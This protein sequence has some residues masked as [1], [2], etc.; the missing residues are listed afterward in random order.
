MQYTKLGRTGLCVSVTGLGCGGHSRLGLAKY[1]QEHAAGIVRAA[2][3]QGINI[4]DTSS[5]YGTE[6][7]IGRGLEGLPRDSIVI[8]T[9]FPPAT[10]GGGIKSAKELRETLENS[11]RLLKM[12]YIDVYLLHML[13]AQNYE[14]VRDELMPEMQ[15]ARQ[16]G[17]IRFLGASESFSRDM[18]HEMAKIA[19]PENLFDVIMLG[20]NLLNSSAEKSVL[21]W[22]KKNGV[23]TLC[24]YAVRTA[25]SNP[26]ALEKSIET[27]HE[28]GQVD[29]NLVPLEGALDFLVE[30]G[31]ASSIME[32]AYRF[33]RHQSGIDVTFTGT[34]SLE[35][36]KENI[37][38]INMPPLPEA[39]LKRIYAMFGNVD[40][41]SG[42]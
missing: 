1:G 42:E 35:H 37:A 2:Y 24:M 9:K 14:R 41:V 31:H 5:A 38:A 34:S 40:C 3:D 15:K 10:E 26:Q 11:L 39:A 23:G 20:Y 27:M 18:T 25:L 7:I 12:E 6:E 19:L 29:K 16:Q 36:L 21:P 22:T 28:S 30:E 17:K 8:S 4:F 33:C 13:T 32:A